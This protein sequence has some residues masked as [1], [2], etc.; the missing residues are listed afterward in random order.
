[1]YLLDTN[2]VSELVRR[3]P[4]PN[5]LAQLKRFASDGLFLNVVSIF[6]L[7][8][9]AARSSKPASLW[10]RIA[11][12]ILPRF[13]IIPFEQSDALAAGDLRASLAAKGANIGLQDIL[14]AGVAFNRRLTFVT[15]NRSDF[16]RV[17]GLRVE[18]WF[19]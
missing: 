2:I 17:V 9:G 18:N 11:S 1:M 3:A 13:V 8:Y 16:D 14:L 10:A 19:E 5:V 4:N 12:E 7:R 15:R 6:E